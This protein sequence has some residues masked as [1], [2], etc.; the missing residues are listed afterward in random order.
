MR[1]VFEGLASVCAAGVRRA[2]QRR[3]H[4]PA[5]RSQVRTRGAAGGRALPC[6][7]ATESAG[8]SCSCRA[9]ALLGSSA[10]SSHSP[11]TRQQQRPGSP[12]RAGT[13]PGWSAR[14]GMAVREQLACAPVR[15]LRPGRLGLAAGPQR[16]LLLVAR[17][18]PA[19]GVCC[20][21]AVCRADS[22]DHVSVWREAALLVR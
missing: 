9:V 21:A 14:Q 20:G 1:R 12:A 4:G 18:E 19:V 17:R 22:Q 13:V 16:L 10:P 15:R 6:V 2:L 5:A 7:L 8:G 3:Q 11:G